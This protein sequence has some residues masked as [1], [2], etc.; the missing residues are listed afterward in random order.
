MR[1][2]IKKHTWMRVEGKEHNTIWL[3][4]NAIWLCKP[5]AFV[6]RNVDFSFYCFCPF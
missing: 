1:E 3:I 4:H 5:E 2:R 6:H